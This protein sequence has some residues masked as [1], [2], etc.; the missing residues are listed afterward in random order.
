MMM[1][2]LLRYAAPG[3]KVSRSRGAF[4]FLSLLLFSL[5]LPASPASAQTEEPVLFLEWYDENEKR[6]FPDSLARIAIRRAAFE[7]L[8]Q[9]SGGEDIAGQ[10]SRLQLDISGHRR[11]I[12]EQLAAEG[13]MDAE[14]YRSELNPAEDAITLQLYTRRGPAYSLGL[15]QRA[16]HIQHDSLAPPDSDVR[17]FEA[18]H[19]TADGR[20]RETAVEDET[21]KYLEFWEQR[22]RLFARVEMDSLQV[23]HEAREVALF[24]RII[25]GP[26]VRLSRQLFPDVLRNDPAFLARITELEEGELLTPA[27]LRNARIILE[28]TGLFRNVETPVL[29]SADG[30]FHLLYELEERRTNAFDLLIGYVPDAD[31]SG[32]TLIGNGELLLRNVLVSGSQLDIR[33]D[34]LQQFVTRLDLGYEAAYIASTPFGGSAR[35]RL[36]QQDSTYQTREATIRG[37]YR[38]S[39]STSLL[40][41]LRQH[42]SSAG[43]VVQNIGLRALNSSTL[44]TG[45]GLEYRQTDRLEN[46]TKGVSASLM[47]E[48][49]IKRIDDERVN[50]FTENTGWRQQEVRLLARAY[51][52]PLPRQVIAPRINGY[53]MLSPHYTETDLNRFGGAKSLRGFREEQFQSSHMLWGDLEYRYL[54]DRSSYAFIF[55]AAGYYERPV[56]V[57]DKRRPSAFSITVQDESRIQAENEFSQ[58]QT[59]MLYSYGFGFSYDTPVGIIRFSYALS[60]ADNFANGK[61]HVGIQARL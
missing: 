9:N 10:L 28:N 38:L 22:G 37:R 3:R 49:G 44:F 7:S 20:Y 61:V 32:S 40:A 34:R 18:I 4:L 41:S 26:E 33:F 52:N 11:Y 17:A 53:L 21:L 27:K 23:D 31:G 19:T 29:I 54:L 58:K 5:L 30:E 50:A 45:I 35:F 1:R 8:K 60:R 43:G 12:I 25:P 42:I 14:V 59:E 2:Y 48:T 56:L 57:F 47:A 46:P 6:T 15:W 24:S 36:E 55:G 39:S 51:I 13:F 16:L